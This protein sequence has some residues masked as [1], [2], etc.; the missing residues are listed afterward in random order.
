MHV[1]RLTVEKF[2]AT[3][4]DVQKLKEGNPPFEFWSYVEEIPKEDFDGAD[5]RK[6][7]ISH[8]YQMGQSYQHVLIQSQHQGVAMALVLDLKNSTV[9]GHYLLNLN[10]GSR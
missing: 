8:V 4:F 7:D 10:E 5:C 2:K 3:Q 1:N 6:G 9:Y